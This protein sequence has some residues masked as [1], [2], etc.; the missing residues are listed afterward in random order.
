MTSRRKIAVR[1]GLL[2]IGFVLAGVVLARAFNGF[3]IGGVVD[4]I[5]ALSA[6][7]VGAL[8]G[9]VALLIVLEAYLSAAFVPGLSVWHGG[10]AWLGSNAV[11]SVVPGPSDIPLRY[12]MFRSW[13]QPTADAA[14]ATAGATVLNTAL[15][16]V[17]PAVAAV[18]LAV[19][20]VDLG[21]VT[22][23]VLT[24]CVTFGVIVLACGFLFGTADR[25]AT[26]GKWLDRTWRSLRRRRR[27]PGHPERL[28]DALV[29]QRA[30]TLILV[31]RAWKQIV[32]GSVAVSMVQA[33]L[34]VMCLRAVGVPSTSAST[35][36]LICI[37]AIVRGLTVLPTMPGDAGLSELAFVSL[38]TQVSGGGTV[39]VVTAG[40]L[41]YRALTWVLLIPIGGAAIAIWRAT[42]EKHPT[43][44]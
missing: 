42:L 16:L 36:A 28:A 5:G 22:P 35:L 13:G 24:G 12:R 6:V 29:A 33:G 15:K 30:R 9:M 17:L 7:E 37:W 8:V 1:V 20:N 14:V 21:G 2:V 23:V 27:Y 40:V 10:L 25:T 4:A 11:A 41:I 43:Q 38:V 32:I 31:G 18:G 44:P 3:D 26:F 39:N 34:F 19:G